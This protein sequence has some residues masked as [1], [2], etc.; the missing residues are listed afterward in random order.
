MNKEER[1]I[2][3]HTVSG[4]SGGMYCGDSP[5]MQN[6]LR[7]GFMVSVGR[8]S[9][10]PDEYFAITSKGRRAVTLPGKEGNDV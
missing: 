3:D 4:A 7:L 2:L 6:L 8:K 9:F 10:V 1:A 5:E